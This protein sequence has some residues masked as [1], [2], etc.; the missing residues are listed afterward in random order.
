MANRYFPNF[1]FLSQ[2]ALV[3]TF[4]SQVAHWFGSFALDECP[5]HTKNTSLKEIV[6]AS[7]LYLCGTLCFG[8]WYECLVPM[9]GCTSCLNSRSASWYH[10]DTVANSRSYTV[11]PNGTASIRQILLNSTELVRWHSWKLY[12][13]WSIFCLPRTTA[14]NKCRETL[15]HQRH[16][17]VHNIPQHLL[18][19]KKI[20]KI[21]SLTR[22][23]KQ[24]KTTKK[25]HQMLVWSG[26]REQGR[27]KTCN[28]FI[29]KKNLKEKTFFV[30]NFCF[31][32]SWKVF[33]KKNCLLKISF[34]FNLIRPD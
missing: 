25:L 2:I 29:W 26:S 17:L 18:G 10:L 15:N 19:G 13:N 12:F 22:T 32:S 14:V 6:A 27:S 28:S 8:C 30:Q 23:K 24:I 3:W 16:M 34:Y 9:K 5:K 20:E 1:L 11:V 7:C 31:S 4:L 33:T 21:S